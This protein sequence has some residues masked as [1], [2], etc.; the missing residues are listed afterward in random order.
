[1]YYFILYMLYTINLFIVSNNNSFAIVNLASSS[2][3]S[4]KPS[5]SSKSSSS[6]SKSLSSSIF[7]NKKVVPEGIIVLLL[8]NI[9]NIY[10]I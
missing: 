5:S 9:Y 6:L 3:S 4:S 8:S 1:M 7:S 2:K 10:V